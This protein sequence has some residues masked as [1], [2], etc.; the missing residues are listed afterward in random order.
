MKNRWLL[1]LALALLVGILALV[2]LY[3]P[4]GRQEPPG[5]PL[6]ALKAEA[7]ERVRIVRTGQPETRIEKQGDTWRLVAPRAARANRFRM[8]DFTGLAEAR[9]SAHFAAGADL[10]QYGLDRPLA[11]VFLNDVEIRFGALHPLASEVYVLHDGEVKLL[12]AAL[13]RAAT[14]P[15][16]DLFDAGLLDE[17]AKLA[18]LQLPGF[19]LQQNDTGG[20]VRSPELKGLGS[21][22]INR[23]V[24]E[25][26]YARALAVNPASTRPGRERIAITVREGEAT[27][28]IAFVVVARRPELVLRRLDEQLDYHFP[29]EAAGRLL[30]LKPEPPPGGNHSAPQPQI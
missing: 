7:V 12:P 19:R 30:E 25:W 23:L 17:N 26:R 8:G 5:T 16:D 28:E 11:T 3:K 6:T 29:A 27:R 9:A 22:R 21:D 1:N 4:G 24:D 18:A 14:V 10:K 2:A 20:W 15:L 13:L